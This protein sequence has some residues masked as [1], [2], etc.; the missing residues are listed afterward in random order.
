MINNWLAYMRTLA[1]CLI[2][3]CAAC[4]STEACLFRDTPE[5]GILF[6][7]VPT[8]I[9]APVVIEAT[10]YDAT[11]N[12]G[13]AYDRTFVNITLMKARVDRVIKGPIDA[14]YLKIFAYPTSCGY[15]GVGRG[16]IVGT[17]RNDPQRG[18]M[19]EAVQ[20]ANTRDWSQEFLAQHVAIHDASKCFKNE[21]GAPECRVP[22]IGPE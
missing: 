8:D 22:G 1:V 20:K 10:I 12:V 14:K 3:Y 7:H 6:E 18:I 11:D 9:D 13:Y 15:V 16:I 19:L 5:Q 4:T 2:A 17:L 21:L